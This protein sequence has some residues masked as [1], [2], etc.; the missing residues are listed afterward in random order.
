MKIVRKC[1]FPKATAKGSCEKSTVLKDCRSD[2]CLEIL[3][4]KTAEVMAVIK[5]CHERLSSKAAD[6][7]AVSK[8]CH[9]SLLN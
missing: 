1:F 2:G 7:M 4:S 3:S 8:D 5:G 9:Q 6:V